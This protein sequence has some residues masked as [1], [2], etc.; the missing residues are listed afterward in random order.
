MLFFRIVCTVNCPNGFIF[1]FINFQEFLLLFICIGDG[2]VGPG[3]L[4]FV[5]AGD[6]GF[7]LLA[8]RGFVLF[9][10]VV[11]LLDFQKLRVQCFHACGGFVFQNLIEFR[12]PLR[13][14]V[15][16]RLLFF[17]FG[18]EGVLRRFDAGII[19][20]VDCITPGIVMRFL[21]R[22]V[23]A[24]EGFDGGNFFNAIL[25]RR[26]FLRG[27]GFFGEAFLFC[28]GFGCGGD[29][30]LAFLFFQ[31]AHVMRHLLF[32]KCVVVY[33][34]FKDG[35]L[36]KSVLN[37]EDPAVPGERGFPECIG[38]APNH[39]WYFSKRIDDEFTADTEGAKKVLDRE[40]DF[41]Q[42]AV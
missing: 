29:S 1:L 25:F 26:L 38:D 24:E 40:S 37:A 18:E 32:K 19:E 41:A 15:F 17:L 36:I 27:G 5:V 31:D 39:V 21:Y 10:C 12:F 33:R 3:A 4:Q 34:F 8:R 30:C 11:R 2:E 9:Q 14:E 22:L 13:C 23:A 28:G 20:S 42:N 7:H 16:N 35:N 6:G